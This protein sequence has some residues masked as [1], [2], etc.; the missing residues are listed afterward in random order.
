M[1]I[2]LPRGNEVDPGQ[3]CPGSTNHHVNARWRLPRGNHY[4]GVVHCPGFMWT[5]PKRGI[6]IIF[7]SIVDNYAV[8]EEISW[9]NGT[10]ASWLGEILSSHC[11]LENHD[12]SHINEW[13]CFRCNVAKIQDRQEEFLWKFCSCV[14]HSGT[15][16]HWKFLMASV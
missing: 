9:I 14:C 3:R 13:K 10:E 12:T 5:G 6:G 2:N 1:T 4:P 8:A 11:Q 7:L 16:P 15:K